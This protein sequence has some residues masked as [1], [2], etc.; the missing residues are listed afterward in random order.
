MKLLR[1]LINKAY[2]NLSIV[3][4]LLTIDDKMLIILYKKLF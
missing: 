2:L 4:T 1:K 3:F